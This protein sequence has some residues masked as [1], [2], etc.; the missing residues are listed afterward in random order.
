[1]TYSLKRICAGVHE[2]AII[3]I[4][5]IGANGYYTVSKDIISYDTSMPQHRL[6]AVHGGSI[7][8]RSGTRG[9]TVVTGGF[10]WL[11]AAYRH[12][13][14]LRKGTRVSAL[15]FALV[16]NGRPVEL[17]LPFAWYAHGGEPF[18]LLAHAARDRWVKDD[19]ESRMRLKA[20]VILLLSAMERLIHER[21]KWTSEFTEP[22]RM[23]IADLITRRIQDRL[24]IN[25]IAEVLGLSRDYCSRL[26]TV[27][28]R[29]SPRRYILEERMKA[30]A[31]ELT[32]SD[33]TIAAVAERYGYESVHSFGRL[34]K[35]VLG[36]SPA[37]LRRGR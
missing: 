33:S 19:D 4:P 1:M 7:A 12:D 31:R 24:S 3:P 10:L 9:C 36:V 28:F 6:Y 35:Q 16:K 22:Q 34:F 25:D 13:I 37:A 30:I 17:E 27:T 23:K 29:M 20:Y 5:T 32:V 26:F 18:S 21:P 11:S 8:A 14:T 2:N 15:D